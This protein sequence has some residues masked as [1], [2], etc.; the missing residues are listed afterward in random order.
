MLVISFSFGQFYFKLQSRAHLSW[1]GARKLLVLVH[2]AQAMIRDLDS[3]SRPVPS[4]FAPDS[5]PP[6]VTYPMVDD[7]H[8]FKD[9][10]Y[11]FQS[12]FHKLMSLNVTQITSDSFLEALTGG[13][14][15]KLVKLL[16]G[17]R[18]SSWHLLSPGLIK[19]YVCVSETR[20]IDQ[21]LFDT[22]SRT[23]P[24]LAHYAFI[25]T[26]PLL[27]VTRKCS[28]IKYLSWRHCHWYSNNALSLQLTTWSTC[29]LI[30]S[31]DE[32][33]ELKIQ[34]FYNVV[35]FLLQ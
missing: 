15:I 3:V 30:N 29:S 23:P 26:V 17:S 5:A 22:I 31:P 12:L 34:R 27:A 1:V 14:K 7:V 21:A 4:A 11:F 8:C 32:L 16:R 18:Y 35:F 19:K 13:T 9:C 6:E 2:P 10:V 25:Y 20:V 24:P 28:L 33:S